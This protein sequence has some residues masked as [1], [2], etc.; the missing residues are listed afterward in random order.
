[1]T[2]S[3]AFSTS[4]LRISLRKTVLTGLLVYTLTLLAGT[5]T[6]AQ[7]F[8]VVHSFARVPL[9]FAP[10]GGLVQDARG[11]LY[12]TTNNGGGNGSGSVYKLTNGQLGWL[13]TALVV[14]RHDDNGFSPAARLTLGPDGAFYGTTAYGG[15]PGGCGG[16]GCGTIFRLNPGGV[17]RTVLY[18]FSGPDGNWP[19]GALAF[20][21]AGNMYGTTEMGG[22]V[23]N[24][25]LFKLVRNGNQWTYSVIYNFDDVHGA[26]EPVAGVVIDSAGNLYGTSLEGG[27]SD[28]GVVYELSPSSGGWSSRVLHSFSA[29]YGD[30][31]WPNA[32]LIM[33]AAGNLYGATAGGGSGYSGT[34]FELSP[35]G[36][37]W[38]YATICNL[39]GPGNLPGPR[40]SLV[41]D[42]SGNLYGAT[43]S[44]GAYGQGSVFKVVQSN[45]EW[46]CYTIHDFNSPSD[47]AN[48][49]GDLMMDAHGN[50]FGTAWTGGPYGGGTVWEITP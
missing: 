10:Y 33:D 43:Y 12:G 7:T 50:V 28:F 13:F 18:R 21:S 29:G 9:G 27:D 8:E 47:G 2:S 46:A 4:I 1:M 26:A 5:T 11:N 17:G 30:G 34:A 23:G 48:P 39:T 41:M 31:G 36:N 38:N 49:I 3:I 40:G 16:Y 37:N 6:Q 14:F 32:G 44:A 20:D 42:A 45:G 15:Y 35:S 24:G 19:L 25:T 22:T